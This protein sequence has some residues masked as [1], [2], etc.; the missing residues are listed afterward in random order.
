V[1]ATVERDH[2]EQHATHRLA[3]AIRTT[4]RDALEL[5]AGDRASAA[6]DASTEQAGVVRGYEIVS[7]DH[8]LHH[9]WLCI[10][11]ENLAFFEHG[12]RPGPHGLLTSIAEADAMVALVH[13]G[14]VPSEPGRWLVV[15]VDV[16]PLRQS[17]SHSSVP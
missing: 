8:G 2:P 15:R 10:G 6:S 11:L 7:L 5:L 1:C 12:V 17:V 14:K 3:I 4:D 9:S 16:I 13:D